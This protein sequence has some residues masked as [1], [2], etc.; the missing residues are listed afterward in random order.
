MKKTFVVIGALIV[1]AGLATCGGL[2]AW[3]QSHKDELNRAA[4]ESL[5][6][7]AHFGDGKDAAA[8]VGEAE[9]RLL[10]VDGVIAEASNK[11]FLE[12]CL[13]TASLPAGFC[14][15]I[16]PRSELRQSIAWAATRC[17]NEAASDAQ[18]CGRL[19]GAVQERCEARR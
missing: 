18:R 11:V 6:D 16:P 15:G 1:V 3:L 9:A 5:R 17:H 13:K 12:G 10:H 2:Y 19:I 8:C 7:G 14:E 4:K